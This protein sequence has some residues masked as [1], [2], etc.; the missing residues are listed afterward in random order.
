MPRHTYIYFSSLDF[1]FIL[2]IWVFCLKVYLCTMRVK[3]HGCQKRT[4]DSLEP[5]FR[6]LGSCLKWVLWIDSG[7]LEKMQAVLTAEP[8]LQP[9]T[10]TLNPTI[11]PGPWFFYFDLRASGGC[12]EFSGWLPETLSTTAGLCVCVCSGTGKTWWWFSAL[13]LL[14][15]PGIIWPLTLLWEQHRLGALQWRRCEASMKSLAVRAAF[16][17]SLGEGLVIGRVDKRKRWWL[18]RWQYLLRLSNFLVWLDYPKCMKGW[19]FQLLFFFPYS[20]E[21]NVKQ[22]PSL[23]LVV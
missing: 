16:T 15:T 5:E 14:A 19:G 8:P 2:C 1:I 10:V 12:C 17:E 21:P 7:P 11:L 22:N 6:A 4:S 18:R 9:K 20:N 13:S 23:F 3:Y